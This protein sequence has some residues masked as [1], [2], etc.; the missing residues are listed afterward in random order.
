MILR[1]AGS[2]SVVVA[3]PTTA[4]DAKATN[5][6]EFFFNR[7]EGKEVGNSSAEVKKSPLMCRTR[8]LLG[9]REIEE[10]EIG[11]IPKNGLNLM[12]VGAAV[13]EL[14]SSIFEIEYQI[15]LKK[16]NEIFYSK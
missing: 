15:I 8:G 1:S 5:G 3:S 4:V 9:R 10:G 11:L 7:R 16:E 6:L 13:A 12:S 2:F 14:Q